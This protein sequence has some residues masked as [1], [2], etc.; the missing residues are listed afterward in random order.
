MTVY[1]L[2]GK[3]GTGKS[4]H[5]MEVCEKM[6][7]ESII[8]DGLFIYH[9]NVVAGIS[10]KTDP[11]KIGAVKAAL[12]RK[13]IRK[14]EVVKKIREYS[15]SSILILGTSD[16][17]AQMIAQRLELPKISEIIHIEDITTQKQRDEAVRQRKMLGKHIVPAPTAQL[18]RQ[19]SGYFLDA[20]RIFRGWGPL[21]DI[22]EEKTVVRPT[23]S[24]LGDFFITEKTITDIVYITGRQIPEI[25]E[26]KKVVCE[27]KNEELLIKANA[28]MRKDSPIVRA[29][30]ALQRETAKQI[31]KMTGFNVGHINI[32]IREVKSSL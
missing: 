4:Y 32:D 6:N 26:L 14:A 19:F 3:S 22:E 17:M 25:F 27:K 23:Y 2:T 16:R 11:T 30:V 10:A 1:A 12:F 20:L 5:A 8:D 7:I 31:D 28:V 15:P 24:Y 18:K 29:A 9:N 13:D 21:R